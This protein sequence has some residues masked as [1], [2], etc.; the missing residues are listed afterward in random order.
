[1]MEAGKRS[2]RFVF[3]PRPRMFAASASAFFYVAGESLITGT[4]PFLSVRTDRVD[5]L[6]QVIQLPP[7]LRLYR[8]KHMGITIRDVDALVADALGNRHGAEAHIDQ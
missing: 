8:R 4:P 7:H 5:R 2:G 1:M 6:T 3:P